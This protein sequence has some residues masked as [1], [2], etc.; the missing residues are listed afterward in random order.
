MPSSAGCHEYGCRYEYGR[1]RERR[2]Y[3]HQGGQ[4][5]EFSWPNTGDLEKIL[6]GGKRT[7]VFPPA[8]NIPGGGRAYPGKG[9]QVASRG[10]IEVNESTGITFPGSPASGP[11]ASTSSASIL[12]AFAAT[13]PTRVRVAS[14]TGQHSRCFTGCGY[15]DMGA[16]SYGFGKIDRGTVRT[17]GESA[18]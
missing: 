15:M 11:A 17:R 5:I 1:G 9:L 2:S 7:V 14:R 3:C 4:L 6:R 13:A 12:S 16:I 10:S 8:E 18:G